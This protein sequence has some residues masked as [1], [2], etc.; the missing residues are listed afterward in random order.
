MIDAYD[1][2]QKLRAAWADLSRNT[3]GGPAKKNF[4]RIPVYVKHGSQ[5]VEVSNVTIENNKVILELKHE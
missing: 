3:S 5:L 2:Q 1:I 4:P